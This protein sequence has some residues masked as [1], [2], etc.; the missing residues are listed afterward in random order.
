M[1]TILTIKM[2]T[3]EMYCVTS[4][5]GHHIDY[6]YG[7][8]GNILYYFFDGQHGMHCLTLQMVTILTIKM[9]AMEMYCVTSSNGH[10][11]DYHVSSRYGYHGNVL[12][13]C[14]RF[15]T[16]MVTMYMLVL[17]SVNAG[18]VDLKHQHMKRW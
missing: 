2:V 15:I 9:V 14:F 6:H 4:S 8:H 5:D 16:K 13:Y 17:M 1:V 10:H 18:N 3:M 7:H 12:C 11:I